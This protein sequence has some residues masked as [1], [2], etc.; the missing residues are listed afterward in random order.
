MTQDTHQDN[1]AKAPL[2]KLSITMDKRIDLAVAVAIALFGMFVLVEAR[3]IRPGTIPDPVTS[4]GLAD[5]GG[6]LLIIFG[7]LLAALRLQTWSA[8]P[9]NLVPDEGGQADEEGYPASAL[10]YMGV[11]LAS[12]LWVWLIKPLGFLI[13]TPL[14]LLALSLFMNV[15]SRTKLI[16]FPILF[17]LLTWVAFSQVLSVIMP[18]GPLTSFARSLGL[19]P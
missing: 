13:A 1:E 5:I 15:R 3:N 4:R 8:M 11:A 7:I 6:I 19:T 12:L 10:R 17:T 9:G 16:A 2:E 18:L 14:F